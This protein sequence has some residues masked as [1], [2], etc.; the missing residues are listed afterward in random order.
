MSVL[1]FDIDMAKL[2]VQFFDKSFDN[3]LLAQFAA[4]LK[5]SFI[6]MFVVEALL[7]TTLV[8]NQL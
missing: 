3:K 1:T 8:S 5:C 6:T 4:S 7:A 2:Y